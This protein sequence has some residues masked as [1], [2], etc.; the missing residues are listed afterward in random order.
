MAIGPEAGR[1]IRVLVAGGAGYIGSHT[2]RALAE[3]GHHPVVLDTLAT[4]HAAAVPG[5]PLVVGDVADS[6]LVEATLRDHRIEAVIQFAALK[7]VEASVADPIGYF[8]ANVATTMALAEAMTHAG[9]RSLVFSSS[10]AVYG[11][12]A[13]LPVDEGAPLQPENPYGETKATV[14]RFLGWLERAGGLRSIRLRYFNAAG[15]ALDGSNG[16]DLRHATNLVPLV[17]A[18]ALGRRGPLEIYG[19][20]Y[21][22]P[23]GTAVR[24][25]VHVVD[26]AEAHTAAVDHLIGGGDSATINLGTGSGA[27]VREVIDIARTVTGHG[28]PSLDG[29]RRAGD[30]A[31]IWAA[32]GR[33][34]SVLGWQARLGLEDII[35]SAWRWHRSH[36]DGFGDA[37]D[38]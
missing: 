30:P 17:M 28:I 13:V 31:A 18:T 11:T 32:T 10:A 16:E 4:G 22:T 6:G 21:P 19:T 1:S 12:P 34:R 14:E 36:P 9:V 26:L 25:Y 37:A 3:R 33:A 15:A 23:D 7:S 35:A 29:P 38:G 5:V 27:S 20:D 8:R 24:D 2:V